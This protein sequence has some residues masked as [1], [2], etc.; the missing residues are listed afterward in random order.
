MVTQNDSKQS[1]SGRGQRGGR[2][3]GRGRMGGYAAGPGGRCVCPACGHKESHIAGQ[4][5]NQKK[6]PECGN[7]MTRA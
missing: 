7:L 1:G 2:G 4:P 5:C 6:C 3:S